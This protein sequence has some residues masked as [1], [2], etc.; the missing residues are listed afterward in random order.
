ML[1]FAPSMARFSRWQLGALILVGQVAGEGS[2]S[3]WDMQ[4]PQKG[5]GNEQQGSNTKYTAFD[6]VAFSFCGC[7]NKKTELI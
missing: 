5:D 3:P 2:E 6:H 1:G 7:F 4:N